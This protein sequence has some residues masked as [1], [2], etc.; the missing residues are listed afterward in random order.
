MYFFRITYSLKQAKQYFVLSFNPINKQNLGNNLQS[1]T[2]SQFQ[3]NSL[4]LNQ[5]SSN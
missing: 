4:A 1:V 3:L 2:A 5:Q